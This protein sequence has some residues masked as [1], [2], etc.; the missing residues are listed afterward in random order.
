[1]GENVSAILQ[2]KL[3][4][5]CK[6]PGIIT[7]PCRIGNSRFERTMLDSG[8]SISVM[9]LSMYKSLNIGPLK[10]T[11]VVLQLADRTNA[12]PEGVVEDV[13]VQVDGLVFP[14]DFYVVDMGDDTSPNPALII[15]GRPFLR[16]ARAIVDYHKGTLTM[17]FDGE[18]IQFAI[19]EA[20]KYPNEYHSMFSID[21]VDSL[22]QEVFN[23]IGRDDLDVAISNHL[24]LKKEEKIELNEELKQPVIA[25][26][27]LPIILD[28]FEV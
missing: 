22:V 7:I 23:L 14:V 28:K 6:D 19:Y 16:T 5:K 10:E 25:S 3:P 4:P 24:E 2:R 18:K 17:E 1:M 15:L 8:A 12:Y 9:P 26:H 27:S 13:L 21:A 20:M 11:G